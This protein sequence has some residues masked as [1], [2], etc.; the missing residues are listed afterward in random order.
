M[1]FN[2]EVIDLCVCVCVCV[3][4]WGGGGGGVESCTNMH[5]EGAPCF[6]VARYWIQH[7]PHKKLQCHC[8]THG[9]QM[10][11]FALQ[12]RP[13]EV[14]NYFA[15]HQLQLSTYANQLHNNLTL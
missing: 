4:V 3:C 12:S 1:H 5:G 7:C 15:S 10:G 11:K 2:R 14:I 9:I 6:Y 8:E 13:C